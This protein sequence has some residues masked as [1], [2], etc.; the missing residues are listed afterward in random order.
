[1]RQF[2]L[3]QDRFARQY[4]SLPGS[5]GGVIVEGAGTTL[6]G[7][8]H[9]DFGAPKD[10]GRCLGYD[11]TEGK[12]VCE[13][14]QASA[15]QERNGIG[16]VARGMEMEVGESVDSEPVDAVIAM[17]NEPCSS[18][19][20]SEQAQPNMERDSE[21]GVELKHETSPVHIKP[22]ETT[23]TE[24]QT[25]P[26]T[27]K[28]SHDRHRWFNI[29]PRQS[30]DTQMVVTATPPQPPQFQTAGGQQIIATP[31]G[32]YVIATNNQGRH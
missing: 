9:L 24:Q 10:K 26:T 20:A 19:M 12:S 27:A 30:C 23:P 21:G 31:S 14:V 1:M 16:S 17:E 32:Q 6:A 18:G 11:Q 13:E 25:P 2:P 5:V 4:W 3:G 15:E 22:A 8:V 7:E 28:Q 29:L